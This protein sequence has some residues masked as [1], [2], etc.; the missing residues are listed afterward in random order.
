[1]VTFKYDR[2]VQAREKHYVAI[3]MFSEVG[4]LV[5]SLLE[6]F[7]VPGGALSGRHNAG[8]ERSYPSH[9]I[10]RRFFPLIDPHIP[11]PSIRFSERAFV[12]LSDKSSYLAQ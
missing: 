12:V 7:V 8:R 5:L 2:V 1:M 6:P 9:K 4:K 11:P 3:F 10:A